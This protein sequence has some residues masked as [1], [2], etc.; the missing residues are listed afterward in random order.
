LLF[1]CLKKLVV[2]RL[3]I[4]EIDSVQE[5]I[6]KVPNRM[7]LMGSIMVIHLFCLMGKAQQL[8]FISFKG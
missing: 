5:E 2:T 8:L 1:S 3:S 4:Y 7:G 6:I